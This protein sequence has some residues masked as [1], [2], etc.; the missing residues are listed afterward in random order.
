[1]SVLSR[2]RPP[3]LALAAATALLAGLLGGTTGVAVAGSA[4][5]PFDA[6]NQFIG[7]QNDASQNK[8]NSAYGNTWPGATV[9]FGMVQF[10]PTTYSTTG[11]TNWGGYEYDADQ[12]RGFGLTRLSGT[13]CAGT[14][15]AFDFP[16]LPF[17]G[18]LTAGGALPSSPAT[19][20]RD[21]YLGY[22]HASEV[23]QPGYYGVTLDNDV[24]VAL[25]ATTRTGVASFDFPSP[26]ASPAQSPAQSSTQSSTLLFDVAGSNNGSSASSVTIKGSTVSGWTQTRTVCGGGTYRIYF[27][28]SFD[29]AFAGSGTWSGA[30]VTAGAT[31]AAATTSHGS[32]AF[33]NFAPGS[34]VTAKI[35]ISYVSEANAALNAATETAHKSLSQVRAQ[36]R[37]TWQQALSTVEVGGG[38][39]DQ[40]VKF[41]TALYHSL[42]HPN[43]YEDVN[44]QYFGFDGQVRTVARGRH[45]YATYS[46]WDIYRG[47]AQLI[48]LLF[49]K[50]GSDI[51]QSI[52]DMATQTGKWPNWPHDGVSQ[53]KMSGDGLQVVL[54]SIDAFGSTDYDRT[55]ALRSMVSTQTLPATSSNRQYLLQDVGLGW[56]ESR[57]G[58]SA[59]SKTLEYAV[60]DFAIAQLASRLGDSAAYDTFVARAQNWRNLLDPATGRIEPRDRSGFNASFDLSTR[61]DQFE[62]STGYQYGWMVPQNMA[63]L[64]AARG[65]TAAATADLDTFFTQLDAGVYSTPY[66]Y[67]SNEADMQTPWIY[68]YLQQPAKTTDVLYRAVDEMYGTGPTGLPGNDDLGGLSSWYVWASIGLYPS[69]YGTAELTVSAPMFS[70]VKISSAGSDRRIT[71]NAPGASGTRRYIQTEKVDGKATTASYL[72]ASFTRGGGRVDFTMGT[73]AGSWGTGAGDVPPSVD[74]GSD[75][76]NGIATTA[77][78]A[79]ATGTADATG[80]SL[81][82]TELAA[83]GATPGAT[84]ADGATGVTFSWPDSAPGQPDSW[85][86][87]GQTVPMGGVRATSLSFLGFATNGPCQGVATVVYADGST[88]PVNVQLTD[89]TPGTAYQF[90]NVPLVTTTGRNVSDGTKD[91]T[92]AKVFATA[93]TAV[94]PAKPIASVILPAATDQ[95]VMHVFDIGVAQQ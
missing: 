58:D 40:R 85:V 56:A 36:A 65:G 88:Q 13:G 90:G 80:H 79:G 7:T 23:A 42:L 63:G 86:P 6:V 57:N 76:Y 4:I 75:A 3:T 28:A 73:T 34:K 67:L 43:T 83:A 68:N 59:T 69:V 46:S 78:G 35:G 93:P 94:D 49:P 37:T 45:E 25:S 33:V 81:S 27:S 5:A 87:H 16:V 19:D 26:G 64:I 52:T 70:S 1:M 84:L 51:N 24:K 20:I 29:T 92:A 62:Q 21:Y 31:S 41:A 47:E 32:G 74:D 44:G 11:G 17:T 15:G 10:T 9:P 71:L 39:T 53:Q 95:G 77:D 66:A 48:A 91:A 89:W 38:S 2:L 30:D 82:R 61:G 14:N 60:D 72:P 18:A 12:L 8:G 22:S 50:V 54:S 55:A